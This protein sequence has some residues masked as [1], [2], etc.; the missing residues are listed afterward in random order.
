MRRCGRAHLL[1]DDT[2][3]DQIIPGEYLTTVPADELGDYVLVGY[4]ETFPNRVE[5]G[6]IVVAGAN[7]GLGLSRESAPVALNRGGVGAVVAESFARIFYR[8]AINV[9]LPIA[10]VDGITDHISD[11]VTK[12]V[13]I[14]TGSVINETIGEG[15]DVEPLV[16]DPIE[17]LEAG[18]LV[19]YRQAGS[20]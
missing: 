1:P 8:N 13:D 14:E 9:G 19:A 16:P 6:N 5:D 7:F 17:I 11:G 18:G 10:V 4:D 2:D 20:D 3:T 15:F 12:R